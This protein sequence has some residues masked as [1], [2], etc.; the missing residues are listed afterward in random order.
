LWGPGGS[1]IATVRKLELTQLISVS[2]LVTTLTVF[3]PTYYYYLL[4]LIYLQP[5]Y[6]YCLQLLIPALAATYTAPMGSVDPIDPPIGVRGPYSTPGGSKNQFSGVL[7]QNR[8][9]GSKKVDFLSFTPI[10]MPVD[11]I[12]GVPGMILGCFRHDPGISVEIH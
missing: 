9:K 1:K 12:R 8:K 5:T 6:Y 2:P 7:S 10:S 11:P 3:Q 4:L